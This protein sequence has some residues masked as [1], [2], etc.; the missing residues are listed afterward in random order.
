MGL[1]S[2]ALAIRVGASG[3]FVDQVAAKLQEA[4]HMNSDTA[5]KILDQLTDSPTN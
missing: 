4:E 3:E 1:Q 2:R 5:K